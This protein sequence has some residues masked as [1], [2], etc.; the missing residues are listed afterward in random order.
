MG[1]YHNDPMIKA[2]VL[3]ELELL[4]DSTIVWDEKLGCVVGCQ[5][6]SPLDGERELLYSIKLG[7][8]ATLATAADALF[9]RM[10]LEDAR[11][12]PLRFHCAIAVGADLSRVMPRFCSWL[13]REKLTCEIPGAI[14]ENT[15]K[16]LYAFDQQ[17]AGH[18]VRDETWHTIEKWARESD[19]LSGQR[20]LVFHGARL[21]LGLRFH[22]GPLMSVY[23]PGAPTSFKMYSDGLIHAIE[24]EA[25]EQFIN[26]VRAATDKVSGWPDWKR[27]TLVSGGPIAPV[28]NISQWDGIRRYNE[29]F[30]DGGK[31]DK[32][33]Q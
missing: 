27:A 8:P 13:I 18:P 6:S 31:N 28:E 12:W 20:A 24:A 5:V 29:G 25:T 22:V 10:F 4:G 33:P 14:H 32:S 15:E 2:R 26:S 9:M 19:S 17:V 3:A 30:A 7:I 21:A 11:G 1:A 16:L 23:G